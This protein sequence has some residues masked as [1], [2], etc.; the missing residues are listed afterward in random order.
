M[1][2]YLHEWCANT[3]FSVLNLSYCVGYFIKVYLA[4][5]GLTCWLLKLQLPPCCSPCF[6]GGQE[7]LCVPGA[8]AQDVL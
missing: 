5:F 2:I 6:Q 4:R 7:L 3:E 1:R 8:A